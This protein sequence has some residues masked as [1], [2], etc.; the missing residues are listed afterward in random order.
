MAV[1]CRGGARKIG[2]RKRVVNWIETGSAESVQANSATEHQSA[3]RNQCEKR[4]TPVRAWWNRAECG[5]NLHA[6]SAALAISGLRQFLS[7]LHRLCARAGKIHRYLG[8]AF[9]KTEAVP[10]VLSKH[11]C[12]VTLKVSVGAAQPALAEPR[13]L[14]T[15]SWSAT[16][17]NN[18]QVSSWARAHVPNRILILP[19]EDIHV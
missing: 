6:S 3:A 14:S 1:G 10:D 8:F 4:G 13:R 17:L 9:A 16:Q 12:P 11:N 7:L 18:Q 5:V 19:A 15:I 2:K